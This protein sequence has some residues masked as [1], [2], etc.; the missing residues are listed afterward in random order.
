[1]ILGFCLCPSQQGVW[2]LIRILT[3]LRKTKLRLN[4]FVNWG[5]ETSSW[6][7]TRRM[8]SPFFN[9]RALMPRRFEP[10]LQSAIGEK[11]SKCVIIGPSH[12]TSFKYQARAGRG[13]W[14]TRHVPFESKRMY[15]NGG[16]NYVLGGRGGDVAVDLSSPNAQIMGT[17][18]SPFPDSWK[19][20]RD[21]G[22]GG[23][24]YQT[25]CT[26]QNCIGHPVFGIISPIKV[27]EIRF[28]NSTFSKRY[29]W[30]VKTRRSIM[31]KWN[32]KNGKMI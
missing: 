32:A 12:C 30:G 29:C 1:M 31:C 9:K 6:V 28:W 11:H 14:H 4:P 22:G 5:A 20:R 26:L 18:A 10:R 2:Q 27:V 3:G 24:S 16:T 19:M 21:R 13:F 15:L 7:I 25:F 23:G 17:A 8:S